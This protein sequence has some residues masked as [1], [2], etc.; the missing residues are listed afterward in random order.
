MRGRG[1]LG[2]LEGHR[3]SHLNGRSDGTLQGTEEVGRGKDLDA[4]N[5]E[6]RAVEDPAIARGRE[7][8]AKVAVA[9][10]AVANFQSTSDDSAV[11]VV[12]KQDGDRITACEGRTGG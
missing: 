6:R 1:R 3:A 2:R 8:G 11:T 9:Q 5:A 4:V 10:V 7:G 12:S